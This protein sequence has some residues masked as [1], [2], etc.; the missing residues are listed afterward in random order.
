[1]CL[2]VIG[3]EISSKMAMGFLFSKSRLV[4][5]AKQCVPSPPDNIIVG[6]W[7][8]KGFFKTWQQDLHFLQ[9]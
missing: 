8:L 7:S 1:M 3:G 5:L 9:S 2:A 6:F 4:F